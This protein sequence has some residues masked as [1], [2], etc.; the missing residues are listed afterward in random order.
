[1]EH[2]FTRKRLIKEELLSTMRVKP[3]AHARKEDLS[4]VSRGKT[5]LTFLLQPFLRF[6]PYVNKNNKTFS[7]LSHKILIF[8]N[9]PHFLVVQ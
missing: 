8:L 2:V 7:A 5:E 3:C 6:Q 9:P 1:M 4:L